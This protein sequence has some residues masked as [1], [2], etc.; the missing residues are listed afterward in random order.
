[1][2][3]NDISALTLMKP[4]RF[5]LLK[6]FSFKRLIDGDRIGNFDVEIVL[7]TLKLGEEESLCLQFSNVFDLKI[8]DAVHGFTGLQLEIEDVL[9]WQIEGA[10]FRVSE[11]EESAFSFY[12]K[13]FFAEMM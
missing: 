12:C 9:N 2:I 4:S 10:A 3:H 8:G 7:T 6:S 5:T 1:V 11:V 13:A